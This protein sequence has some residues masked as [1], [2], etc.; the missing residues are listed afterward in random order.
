MIYGVLTAL[1][2][3]GILLL[4]ANWEST[5]SEQTVLLRVVGLFATFTG[6]FGLLGD[7]VAY[8]L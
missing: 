8:F 2:L 5:D 7:L 3:V 6:L 4:V 1:L